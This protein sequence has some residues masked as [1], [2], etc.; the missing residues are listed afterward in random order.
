MTGI[1]ISARLG[2][3]RLPNKHLINVKGEP[4]ILWLVNRIH[5][6]FADQIERG[7][8]RVFI[9][10]STNHDNRKF[11][12]IVEGTCAEVFYGSDDNIPLR[13]LECAEA[14]NVEHII[15][16]DGDDVLSSMEA[17]DLVHTKLLQG[18]KYVQ[19]EGLPLGMNISGYSTIF[20]RKCMKNRENK[21]LETGWGSIFDSSKKVVLNLETSADYE[22]IRVTLDYEEDAEFFRKVINSIDILSVTDNLLIEQIIQNKLYLV[23]SHL[24]EKYWRNFNDSKNLI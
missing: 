11:E 16:I 17:A 10:T 23:N 22:N 1:F 15:S 2:S 24:A 3:K 19:T 8:L 20:L 4:F 18:A 6:K 21:V 7:E 13:H 9:T 12:D 5:N 14:N